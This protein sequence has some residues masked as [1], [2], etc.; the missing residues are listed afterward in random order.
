MIFSSERLMNIL[1]LNWRC[2]VRVLMFSWIKRM[3]CWIDP[4]FVSEISW[5]NDIYSNMFKKHRQWIFK[6][7]KHCIYSFNL[8]TKDIIIIIILLRIYSFTSWV[9][10]SNSSWL[11]S[12]HGASFQ[13]FEYQ[14]IPSV[15]GQINFSLCYVFFY[16]ILWDDLL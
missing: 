8:H 4:R 7:I 15:S 14:N 10:S 1:I 2:D 9:T 11:G 6:N 5:T 16:I 3:K 13:A 12:S